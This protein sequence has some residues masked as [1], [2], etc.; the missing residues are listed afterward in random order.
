MKTFL[1]ILCSL[2]ISG[3]LSAQTSLTENVLL[4][5]AKCEEQIEPGKPLPTSFK[6]RTYRSNRT[7]T[8]ISF[9]IIN[10]CGSKNQGKIYISGDTLIIHSTDV[11]V[12]DSETTQTLDSLG[13]IV[14]TTTFTQVAEMTFCE[15]LI[16]YTYAFDRTM[17]GLKHLKFHQRL[18]ALK[19]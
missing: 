8:K 15:C 1:A 16:N 2:L 19:E 10:D 7:S 17:D 12:S 9:D 11:R 13:M 18:F 14:E 4:F 3:S 6:L 5:K